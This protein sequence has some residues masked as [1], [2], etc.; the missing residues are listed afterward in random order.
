MAMKVTVLL[1]PRLFKSDN[2]EYF[3]VC[4]K[5][6][7]SN[8][9]T[10]VFFRNVSAQNIPECRITLD[11]VEVIRDEGGLDAVTYLACLMCVYYIPNIQYPS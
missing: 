1:L 11:A 5:E 10:I 3:Y 4:N 8:E 9:P 6:P 2:V 7:L